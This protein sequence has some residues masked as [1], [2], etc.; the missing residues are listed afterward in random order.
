M[1]MVSMENAIAS[2]GGFCVGRSFVV[3]HQRLSGLG[4]CF[5]AS[6]PQL[7]ATSAGMCVCVCVHIIPKPS[8]GESRRIINDEPQRL[9]RL[10]NNT[11][12]MHEKLTQL[13]H[14]TNS[15]WLLDGNC[16]SPILH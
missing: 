16:G 7:L 11:R 9:A 6:L 5:S 4:Y 12:V 13:L 8:P 2:T 10:H 1:I 15:V 14:T 3:D